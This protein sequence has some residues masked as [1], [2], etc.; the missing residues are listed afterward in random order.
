MSTSSSSSSRTG[1]T[2]A[3]LPCTSNRQTDTTNKVCVCVLA[4]P[5]SS[6]SFVLNAP[7]NAGIYAKNE[8]D[9]RKYARDRGNPAGRGHR[10]KGVRS[11][12]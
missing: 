1:A 7:T 11:F 12:C 4:S 8:H 5:T 2:A 9:G 10:T 3:A 6:S